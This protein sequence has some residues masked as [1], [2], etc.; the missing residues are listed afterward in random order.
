MATIKFK[1]TEIM[2]SSDKEKIK[3]IEEIFNKFHLRM[4]AL[5][6]RQTALLEKVVNFIDEKKLKDIREKIRNIYGK[7]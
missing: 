7:Q 5:R 2:I 3:K 4:L 1:S 6:E